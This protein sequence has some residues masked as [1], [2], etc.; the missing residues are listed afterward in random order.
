MKPKLPNA[1]KNEV[2]MRIKNKVDISELIAPYSIQNEDFSY[3]IIKT[4]NRIGENISNLNLT[5]AIIGSENQ[6]IDLSGADAR[7]CCFKRTQFI[8]KVISKRT[9]FRNSN[10]TETFIPKWDYRLA[11]LIGCV[12]CGTTFT[13]GTHYAFGAKFSPA[14]FE[15]L[16]KMCNLNITVNPEI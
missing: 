13:I 3:A 14:L 5:N 15:S 4:F 8:S 7:N 1:I 11:N 16:A 10:F 2:A 12:F 9:D 6:M